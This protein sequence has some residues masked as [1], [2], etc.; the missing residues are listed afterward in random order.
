MICYLNNKEKEP[1]L[2]KISYKNVL[3]F[4]EE[5]IKEVKKKFKNLKYEEIEL[6]FIKSKKHGFGQN[7]KKDY[8]QISGN[9]T[10][11]TDELE[12]NSSRRILNLEDRHNFLN[13]VKSPLNAIG[14]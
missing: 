14:L 5:L 1:F 6:N 11:E 10:L 13:N 12:L 3:F 9:K 7:P 2:E 8:L 4:L